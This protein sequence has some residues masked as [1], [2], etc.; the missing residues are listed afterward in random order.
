MC[1]SRPLRA[2]PLT[3]HE[4]RNPCSK[5]HLS[6]PLPSERCH[7]LGC[8]RCYLEPHP[9]TAAGRGCG[10]QPAVPP[11]PGHTRLGSR[12]RWLLAAGPRPLLSAACLSLLGVGSLVG[13][14]IHCHHLDHKVRT[15]FTFGSGWREKSKQEEYL[16][17]CENLC[18]VQ[19]FA[20][21]KRFY[22]VLELAP[23][24]SVW[25]EPRG[26]AG[27]RG[28]GQAGALGAPIL[29]AHSPSTCC[30]LCTGHPLC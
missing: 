2:C 15:A 20:S 30:V 6:E 14:R 25:P 16:L 27:E 8:G 10:W 21:V 3:P 23:H 28:R 5:C 29:G 12:L 18:E 26:L 13:P 24:S 4:P 9:L 19:I 1:V 11:S 7:P 22:Q 17:T